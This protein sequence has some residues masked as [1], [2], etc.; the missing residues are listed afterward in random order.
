MWFLVLIV[1]LLFWWSNSHNTE[2][3]KK[4][5]DQRVNEVAMQ[6]K[7]ANDVRQPVDGEDGKNGADGQTT[8]IE[9][10]TTEIVTKT[11]TIQGEKGEKGDKGDPAPKLEVQFNEQTG[12]LETKY[13]TDN[14]WQVLIP[15]G[16]LLVG[17]KQ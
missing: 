15:C 13:D 14:F 2:G 9:K 1:I 12:S 11:E 16:K 10:H 8:V 5:V 7:L 6:Q 17:C 3:L 4:Y